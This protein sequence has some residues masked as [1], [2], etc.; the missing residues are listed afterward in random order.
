MWFQ[1][2]DL[3]LHVI[4]LDNENQQPISMVTSESYVWLLFSSI[5]FLVIG[6]QHL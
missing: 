2:F 5:C 3:I 1:Q 6:R 4:E